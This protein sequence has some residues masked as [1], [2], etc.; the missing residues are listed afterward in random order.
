MTTKTT[1]RTKFDVKQAV[2]VRFRGGWVRAV[3]RCLGAKRATVAV[4]TPSGRFVIE[5]DVTRQS[6]IRAAVP[7]GTP[8]PLGFSFPD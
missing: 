5:H 7:S 1:F 2:E 4:L 3:V 8:R 6:D